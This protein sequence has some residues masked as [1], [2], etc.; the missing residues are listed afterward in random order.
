MRW[1][2]IIVVLMALVA[3]CS[4]LRLGYKQGPW[5]AYW[6]LDGYA[7]FNAEQSPKVKAALAHWFAWHRATQL[8]DYAQAL[9]ELQALA[10][11]KLTGAQVCAQTAA[12]Q[13]RA[14]TAYEHAVPAIA[15]QVRAL[16]AEQIQRIERQQNKKL[17]EAEADFLQDDPADRRKALLKRN[18]DRAET[19]YGKLTPAQLQLLTQALAQSPFKPELWLAERRQRQQDILRQLRQ[20]QS[21]HSDAAAVQAGLRQLGTAALV[22]ARP[23]YQAYA[24]TVTQANCALSAAVHNAAGAPQRQHAVN[25]LKAWEDDLQ[26]LI[27]P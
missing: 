5:L 11:E 19:L 7:D 17:A 24:D 22:S 8:P 23:A 6:W 3:G 15:E 1:S 2:G 27:K 21:A 14:E 4:T 25:K 26:A 20:W 18:I 12:W 10:T 16:T 9:A 13:Q